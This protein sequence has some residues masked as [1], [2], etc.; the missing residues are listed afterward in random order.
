MLALQPERPGV[1]PANI[2]RIE[3]G[4]TL[5]EVE[6]ILGGP[7][8]RYDSDPLFGHVFYDAWGNEG[9]QSGPHLIDA[10]RTVFVWGHPSEETWVAVYFDDA[11]SV[12]G[13][14]WR[15][16]ETFLEMLRRL[17]RL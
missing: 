16:R 3:K 17:L 10:S 2:E 9:W 1:T 12:I 6:K 7:G 8:K 11:N 5:A 14:L 15:A 13:K 4:M